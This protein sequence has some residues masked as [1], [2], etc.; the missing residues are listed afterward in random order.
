[1]LAGMVASPLFLGFPLILYR[2]TWAS[3]G[4]EA[5]PSCSSGRAQIGRTGTLVLA[6]SSL[7]LSG[8]AASED[9]RWK[10]ELLGRGAAL[11]SEGFLEVAVLEAT[12]QDRGSQHPVASGQS[13]GFPF[14]SWHPPP[15][16]W[17]HG[18][19][20][21]PPCSGPSGLIFGFA[22]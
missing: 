18:V 13:L 15:L 2:R 5:L 11:V 10:P 16:A 4:V 17:A 3:D 20:A 7:G 12:L 19:L 21:F 14:C 8:W 1:M 9:S 6:I 22:S